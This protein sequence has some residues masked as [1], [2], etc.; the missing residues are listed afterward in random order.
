MC[1]SLG[2]F[3]GEGG[4]PGNCEEIE[5]YPSNSF[6]ILFRESIMDFQNYVI[7]FEISVSERSVMGAVCLVLRIQS[8]V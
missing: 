2:G 6:F 8:E 3:P 4:Y 5:T 7:V 1:C